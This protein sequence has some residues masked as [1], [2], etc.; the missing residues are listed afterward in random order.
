MKSYKILVAGELLDSDNKIEIINPSTLT[1]AGT[2]PNIDPHK[3]VEKAMNAA[4]LAFTTWSTTNIEQ[5]KQLLT[6]F[7]ELLISHKDELSDI[8]VAEIAKSK[9]ESITEIERTAEYIYETIHTYENI[10]LHPL[11]IGEE[12]HNIKGKVGKFIYEPIGIVLAISPFNYPVNLLLSKLAPALIAGNTVVYKPATQG[13]LIGARISELFAEAGFPIGVV[14]CVVGNGRDVGDLLVTNPHVAMISFTGSTGVGNHIASLVSKIPLVLE[15]GGKDPAIVLEDADLELAANEIVKGSLNYNGQ[16][17]T[18]IKR[19]LVVPKVHKQLSE[20]IVEKAK[21]LTVG[22][23]QDNTNITPVISTRSADYIMSLVDDAVNNHNAKSL[24]PYTRTN[25]LIS[26]IILDDVTLEAKVAWEEPFGPL[27]PIIEC[28]NVDECIKVANNSEYGLQA[29][30]FT[31]DISLAESIA[32]KLD[33][34][35]VN[36]NRAPS[37]GPDIFPFT[38]RKNS[39]FGVQGIVDAILSMVKIKGIVYNK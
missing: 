30:I 24:I 17:C 15:M 11:T 39:G 5:R 27:L 25:N 38:G 2:I 22:L 12:T 18:A 9:K 35:S 28:L 8:L 36:I 13:S 20:L 23:P 10:M 19:V 1:P 4:N 32:Y 7:T 14:N 37:R 3:L 16:R 33:C 26:P 29:S 31:N 6:K 34:G 21:K